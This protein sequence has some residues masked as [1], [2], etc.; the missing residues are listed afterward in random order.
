MN[1]RQIGTGVHRAPVAE[2]VERRVMFA[3]SFGTSAT[4]AP[5]GTNTQD[6]AVADLNADGKLDVAAVT[7]SGG[8]SVFAGNGD[9]TFGAR[10][11]VDLSA[12]VPDLTVIRAADLNGDAL[13]D[14]VVT[15]ATRGDVAVLI[16]LGDLSFA[17]PVTY[18]TAGATYDVDL[19]DFDKDGDLDLVYCSG[20]T[21]IIGILLN[22]GA[23]TFIAGA[24]RTTAAP[25]RAIAATDWELDGD[26]DVVVA[27]RDGEN[28]IA[29]LLN[30]GDGTLPTIRKAQRMGSAKAIALAD[31][32]GDAKPDVL[33]FNEIGRRFASYGL[34][35]NFQDAIR[36][37]RIYAEMRGDPV[38]GDYVDYDQDGDRDIVV[39][40]ANG[41]LV[42]VG[43]PRPY[44]YFD[45][46]LFDGSPANRFATADFNADGKP[47]F[48]LATADGLIVL[49]N[50]SSGGGG[51]G[52]G[53]GGDGVTP[54]DT[55]RDGVAGEPA[56]LDLAITKLTLP[57]V[58]V[59][60]DKGSVTVGLTNAGDATASGRVTV[61]L[62]AS[63]DDT[64]D[65]G[66]APLD[67]GTA[68]ANRPVRVAA[69][70][71]ASLTGRFV[72]PAA[73]A[74]GSYS[75]LAKVTPLDVVGL[76]E[77]ATSAS[78]QTVQKVTSFG[79]VGDRRN[80]RYT[81]T[82]ADGTLV[83]YALSGAGTGVVSDDGTSVTLD[84]TTAASRF[85]ATTRAMRAT[86]G[87]DALT[88]I[89]NLTVNGPIAG[90]TGK[91]L[92][93]SGS[94]SVG[95]VRTVVLADLI[96]ATDDVA[97]TLSGTTPV[98]ITLGNVRNAVVISTAGIRSLRAGSWAAGAFATDRITAPWISALTVKQGW[99][100]DVVLSGIGAAGGNALG[101]A[102]IGQGLNAALWSVA[103]NVGAVTVGGDVANGWVANIAG[104]LRSITTKGN[105][106]GGSLAAA[107]VGTFAV[108]GDVSGSTVRAGWYFGADNLADTPDDTGVVGSIAQVAIRN[109]LASSS[110]WAGVDTIGEPMAGG[111]IRRIGAI[112]TVAPTG[113]EF[114][115]ATLPRTVR[116][117]G[118]TLAT[119]EDPRFV[120][121]A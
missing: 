18:A 30:A 104:N 50:G 10:G 93:L 103:G 66:D 79:Q 49:Q 59:P 46:E 78:T 101:S 113:V 3:V 6:V 114:R 77:P 84:G 9:G 85:T 40:Y 57:P 24:T 102:R 2:A 110:F 27:T 21:A 95:D 42:E 112:E 4:L 1:Q 47:D 87:S 94:L 37:S 100:A 62:F 20:T 7:L 22:D 108:T 32:N 68:L 54:G 107:N 5:I 26:V 31:F 65:D 76:S 56:A 45:T 69:G 91:G 17:T 14:L 117:D 35:T 12:T 92:Q 96:G 63:A 116:F 97:V 74:N 118:V 80:V 115:A 28:A 43:Q 83:T 25:S 60:G 39:L 106:T 33:S 72:V 98:S 99:A 119:D 71:T 53:G 61:E 38:G 90:I 64:I 11:D 58:F 13:P 121:M 51:G 88:S 75:V 19:A 15:G 52:G 16:N 55:D 29:V 105:F 73:L 109:S 82:D 89:A 34:E 23:G 111:Q 48:V 70:R 8:V 44:T 41:R 67:T 120:T 81:F 86:S 36:R